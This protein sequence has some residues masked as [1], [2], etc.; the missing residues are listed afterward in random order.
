V[1]WTNPTHA[2]SGL[3]SHGVASVP[4]VDDEGLVTGYEDRLFARVV[5]LGVA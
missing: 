2:V 3:F 5:L 1:A 4:L